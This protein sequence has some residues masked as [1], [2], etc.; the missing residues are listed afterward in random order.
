MHLLSDLELTN[1]ELS[2]PTVKKSQRYYNNIKRLI[3]GTRFLYDDREYVMSGQ[4]SKGAYLRAVG[5]DK[6]NFPAAKCKVLKKNE[7]LVFIG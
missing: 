5:C 2:R 3:P 1:A 6:V 7:G 4:Q